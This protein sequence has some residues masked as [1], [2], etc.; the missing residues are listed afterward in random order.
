M[1]LERTARPPAGD[2]SAGRR[3]IDPRTI[4]DRDV[5]RPGRRFRV[6][7]NF[8]DDDHSAC[9]IGNQPAADAARPDGPDCGLK[10]GV[11]GDIAYFKR[12]T[13]AAKLGIAA[14]VSSFDRSSLGNDR[15]ITFDLTCCDGAPRGSQDNLAIRIADIDAS[16]ECDQI[17]VRAL[18]HED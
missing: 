7:P 14:D 18:R 17:E 12:S 9:R 2:I 13:L 4:T 15:G 11:P 16:G 8:P 10:L 5:P 1:A 3:G 6:A